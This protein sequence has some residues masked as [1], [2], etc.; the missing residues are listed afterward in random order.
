MSNLERALERLNDEIRKVQEEKDDA[1]E[2]FKIFSIN[3]N[4]EIEELKVSVNKDYF[5]FRRWIL[6][7]N[8]SE[9]FRKLFQVTLKKKN[10]LIARGG[11]Q[12]N[13]QKNII[14]FKKSFISKIFK[15]LLI[16]TNKCVPSMLA[17]FEIFFL[18]IF[19]I[20]T[21]W[22]LPLCFLD[23]FSAFKPV[24]F[25]VPFMLGNKKKSQDATLQRNQVIFSKKCVPVALS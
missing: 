23:V 3:V 5:L 20:D 8:L 10:F 15:I 2:K 22:L 17:L 14:I 7:V 1:E 21:E 9:W 11:T 6:V 24:S 16:A 18:V 12:K 13:T 4:K 25:Y 19:R